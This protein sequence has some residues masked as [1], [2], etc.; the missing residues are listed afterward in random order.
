[1]AA[2]EQ[3]YVKFGSVRFGWRSEGQSDSRVRGNAAWRGLIPHSHRRR[4][5]PHLDLADVS[6]PG[7][8]L[9]VTSA[10]V[11]PWVFEELVLSRRFRSTVHVI[12]ARR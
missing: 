2:E 3:R 5:L 4:S 11:V 9:L 8:S 7:K 12:F 6:L 1:M 10:R